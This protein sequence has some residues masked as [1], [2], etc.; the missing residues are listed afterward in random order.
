MSQASNSSAFNT[1][2]SGATGTGSSSIR[3]I[4]TYDT[5]SET[6]SNSGEPQVHTPWTPHAESEEPYLLPYEK[7]TKSMSAAVAAPD[8][9]RAID[10][11]SY[12]RHIEMLTISEEP[13]AHQRVAKSI[14]SQR[15][16]QSYV[17]L[18]NERY[19]EK[20]VSRIGFDDQLV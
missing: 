3:L 2:V 8:I 4:D 5:S 15:S 19:R 12:A 16:H 1:V 7:Q 17:S 18:L 13:A 11:D 6:E 9:G 20:I 10:L 14:K